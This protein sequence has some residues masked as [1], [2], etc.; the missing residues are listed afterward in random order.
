[1]PNVIDEFFGF[2]NDALKI[3]LG[4]DGDIKKEV[5]VQKE[6]ADRFE[7]LLLD[8]ERSLEVT[9]SSQVFLRSQ[10]A[11]SSSSQRRL[12]RTESVSR[13]SKPS[14]KPSSDTKSSS[15]SSTSSKGLRIQLCDGL[16]NNA[17]QVSQDSPKNDF[18]AAHRDM[19]S[20]KNCLHESF[21]VAHRLSSRTNTIS[22]ASSEHSN[23][24]VVEP[25]G[26]HASLYD[27]RKESF[28]QSK[29]TAKLNRQIGSTA[30]DLIKAS[31]NSVKLHREDTI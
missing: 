18:H 7:K 1:M 28:N 19:R 12:S 17:V 21:K 4:G 24:Y 8:K 27:P 22:S 13:S 23:Q 11:D 3:N 26:I 15:S 5:E 25:I 30:D 16:D 2:I 9:P 20:L 6:R 14:K 29:E 10:S 31:L